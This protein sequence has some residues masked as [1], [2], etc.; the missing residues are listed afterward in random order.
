[1]KLLLSTVLLLICS[2]LNAQEWMRV[3]GNYDGESWTFPLQIDKMS[4]FDF[5]DDEKTLRGY[6]LKEDSTEMIVPFN[7]EYLD[8]ISFVNGLTDEEKGHNKY[9][10]FT[11][12]ITTE[13][14]QEIVDKYQWINCHFSLDGKGEYS[15]YSGTCRIRGRGNSS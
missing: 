14:G 10:V 5:S 7:V 9:R 12:Y 4:Q 15:N 6:A 1:M 13:N 8:S 11:L 3:H 2:L